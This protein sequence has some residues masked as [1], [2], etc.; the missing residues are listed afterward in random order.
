M[1]GRLERTRRFHRS[2]IY[3][4]SCRQEGRDVM[5][6]EKNTAKK[7][8]L[9]EEPVRENRSILVRVLLGVSV[10]GLILYSVFNIISQQA[11][12]AQLKKQSEELSVQISEAKQENDEYVRI[13]SSDDESEYMER[14]AVER[15]GYAYP[16][17]RRFYV[18]ERD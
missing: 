18:V 9:P 16:D 4:N 5:S 13:L 2:G 14:I 17:E 1:C 11:Q 7:G 3:G 15:L 8:L 6:D 10:F 12:I